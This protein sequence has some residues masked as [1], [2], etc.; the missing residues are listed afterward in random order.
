MT[1]I[2][3][4]VII[5]MEMTEARYNR[6][7]EARMEGRSWAEIAKELNISV[8]TL[9]RLRMRCEF[10]D[11]CPPPQVLTRSAR[12]SDAGKPDDSVVW[13][14]LDDMLVLGFSYVDVSKNLGEF[15]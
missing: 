13:E 1:L 4:E 9:R 10:A 12:S 6:V 2:N 8:S 7:T 3:I 5:S 11:P 15:V 14:T